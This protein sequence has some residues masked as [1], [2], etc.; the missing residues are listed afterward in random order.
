MQIPERYREKI[1]P[2]IA[3]ARSLLEKGETLAAL[4]FVGNL[5][6]N[7]IVP[8]VVDD[9][10]ESSKDD[11]ARTIRQTATVLDADF[12]YIVREAWQLP[13]KYMPRYAEILEQYGSIGASPY[14]QD[15]AAFS[16]ETTHGTWVASPGI[17]PKPPSKKR[18]TIGP[19]VFQHMPGV[20]GRFVGLL[21]DKKNDSGTLH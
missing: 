10:T 16:L 1:D 8:V 4:A 19:V 5:S 7:D 9:S 6:S 20:Q 12:I 2:L 18:R 21:P 11:S 15:V 3:H 13:E 14:A 17:K